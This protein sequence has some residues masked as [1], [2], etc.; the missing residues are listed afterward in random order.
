MLIFLLIGGVVVDR[1]DRLRAKFVCDVVNGLVVSAVA[2][3]AFLDRLEVWHV[4]FASAVVGLVEAFFFPAYTA[5]VPQV[6]PSESL[7]SANSW[8]S[9]SSQVT[10]IVGP[11]VGA[12]IVTAGVARCAT[13]ARDWHW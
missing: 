9:L 10:G 3:Q 12:A 1:F 7:P 4:Y 8:T 5:A 6:T 13:C 2:V 11:A